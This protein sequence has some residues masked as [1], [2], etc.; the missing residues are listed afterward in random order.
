MKATIV[1]EENRTAGNFILLEIDEGNYD[2]EGTRAISKVVALSGT[3]LTTDW[4]FQEGNRL[5]SIS[6]V[7]MSQADYDILVGMQE[8]STG[9]YFLFGYGTNIWKVL[10]QSVSSSKE[11]LKRVVTMS[12]SVV[13]KY[14]DL[15]SS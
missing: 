7:L 15:E 1:S 10:V 14:T 11:G 13:S 2:P 3:V 4:G 8:E 12:L 9:V 6:N 5:I